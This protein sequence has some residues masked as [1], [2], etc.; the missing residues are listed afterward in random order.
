MS[1]S[2]SDTDLRQR[3]LDLIDRSRASDRQLSLLATSS[4]DTVRNIRRG[5]SPRLDSLEAICRV[6]GVRIQLVP[7]DEHGQAAEGTP[8][9]EKRPKWTHRL[10]A[11][12][13]QDLVEIVGRAS[14]KDPWSNRPG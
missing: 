13:R 11:E 6:L 2:G 10:W 8:V 1:A 4:A 14:K 5:S 9:V 3:F 12:I 7:F